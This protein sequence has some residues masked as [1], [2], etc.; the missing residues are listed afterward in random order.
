MSFSFDEVTTGMYN[1]VSVILNVAPD[2]GTIGGL[3]TAFTDISAKTQFFDHVKI[4]SISQLIN[5]I[6]KLLQKLLKY[7]KGIT[8]SASVN[9][10]LFGDVFHTILVFYLKD[11][12]LVENGSFDSSL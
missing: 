10:S 7:F 6:S 3:R 1:F 12:E 5:G 2:G 8:T 9:K 11:S 4:N